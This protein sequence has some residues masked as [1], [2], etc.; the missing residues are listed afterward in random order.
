MDGILNLPLVKTL[1][2][3]LYRPS[4]NMFCGLGS[5]VEFFYVYVDNNWD[6]FRVLWKSLWH[7]GG[8]GGEIE[9]KKYWT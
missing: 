7:G 1:I 8:E 5:S 4:L 2:I 9:D 3:S 6:I